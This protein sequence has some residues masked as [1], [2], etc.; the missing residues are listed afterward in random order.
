MK[1][2]RSMKK[3]RKSCFAVG[4]GK[5]VNTLTATLVTN[6]HMTGTQ[7][8]SLPDVIKRQYQVSSAMPAILAA[9]LLLYPP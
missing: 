8:H 5:R 9:H 2:H 6:A 7:A 4:K 3:S 1:Q